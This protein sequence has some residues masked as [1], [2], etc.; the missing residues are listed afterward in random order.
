MIKEMEVPKLKISPSH[1]ETTFEGK[2]H[3]KRYASRLQAID[4]DQN[5]EVDLAELCEVLEE[6]E[7]SQRNRR[8]LKWVAIVTALF[9]LLTIAAI[10][11]L[12]YAVVDL[13]KDTSVSNNVLVSRDGGNTLATAKVLESVPL[14]ALVNA[15]PQQLVDLGSVILPMD[16]SNVTQILH[17]SDLELNPGVSLTLTSP[18]GKTVIIFPDGSISDVNATAPEGGGSR[19]RLLF[20]HPPGS[21]PS[22]GSANMS[23][24]YV[25][26]S[27]GFRRNLVC[28]DSDSV[29]LPAGSTPLQRK[30]GTYFMGLARFLA[31]SGKTWT[32]PSEQM[33]YQWVFPENQYVTIAIQ[34]GSGTGKILGTRYNY[35]NPKD[36]KF[37]FEIRRSPADGFMKVLDLEGEFVCRHT[38]CTLSYEVTRDKPLQIRPNTANYGSGKRPVHMV[39]WSDR[40]A[41]LVFGL[42]MNVQTD[43]PFTVSYPAIRVQKCC[44]T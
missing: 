15:S 4:K 26:M 21:I 33:H 40:Q 1:I 36:N 6:L 31:E 23:P 10:V 5:G 32:C 37:I 41:D 30:R 19:R 39:G 38:P 24:N 20:G 14:G 25:I 17:I 3:L 9:S 11:G 28:S 16:N 8:L 43:D 12:T 22:G 44:F 35:L 13:S 27:G 18:S 2:P 42:E 34:G 7:T 29:V